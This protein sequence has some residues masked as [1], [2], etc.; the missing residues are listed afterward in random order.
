[1]TEYRTKEQQQYFYQSKRW[2]GKNGLRNQAL[3]RDNY[4]CKLCAKEGSVH[5]DSQKVEGE[6]KSIQLNVHHIKE[7]ETNPHL[8][9]SLDNLMTICLRHHN[10]LHDRFQSKEN[11]WPDEKW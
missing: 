6:R 1:M 9:D 4:E 3:K 8:A 10:L 11:K 2:R 7:I 5:L